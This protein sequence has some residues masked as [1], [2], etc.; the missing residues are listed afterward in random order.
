MRRLT[1]TALILIALATQAQALTILCNGDSNTQANGVPEQERWCER[2]GPL[3]GADAINRGVGGSAI[4]SDIKLSTWGTPLWGDFYIDTEIVNIDPFWYWSRGKSVYLGR[5]TYLPL[6]KFDIVILAWGTNDLNAYK[7]TPARVIKAIKRARRKFLAYGAD[8]Y[9]ATVPAIYEPD[10][11][12][13]VTMDPP[14][15]QLNKKI[16][17]NFPKKHIEFY[18]GFTWADYNDRLHLNAQG[19]EK[20]AAAAVEALAR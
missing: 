20:R 3:L 11:T 14:I 17:G 5:P 16:R 19:H 1:L 13:S 18:D 7:Y 15:Q 10:G 8:V 6:P 9:V 12:K 2:L 4:V